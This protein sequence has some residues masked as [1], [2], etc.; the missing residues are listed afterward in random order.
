MPRFDSAFCDPASRRWILIAAILGSSMG[1]IDGSVVA[2]AI[3]AIRA[4]LG[5]SLAEAQWINNAYMVAISALVL[6]GGSVGDRFG[7]ARIFTLGILVFL[8]A[9]IACAAAPS[10]DALIWARWVQGGG[11]A[12]MVPGSLA[13]IARAYP[14][15]VRGRAI[16]YWAGASAM[17]TA[18]GPVIGGLVM[19]FG[20]DGMWRSVFAVNLPL[21]LVALWLVRRHVRRDRTRPDRGL[22]IPGAVLATL[23]L[24]L[25]AWGCIRIETG[26]GARWLLAGGAAALVLFLLAEW[27]APRPIMPLDLFRD[28]AFRV[29]NLAT[30][31]LYF[32]LS[33]I[34]FFLPMLL[35]SGWGLNE[36]E[37]VLALGPIAVTIALLSRPFGKLGDRLGPVTMICAGSLVVALGYWWLSHAVTTQT[38]WGGIIVPMCVI[39]LGM[40]MVVAP[41]STAIMAGAGEDAGGVASGVNNAVSRVAGLFAVAAMGPVVASAYRRA[42]GTLSYGEVRESS[43]IHVAA[44][45]EAFSA[46]AT[47]CAV[48]AAIAAA[49]ALLAIIRPPRRR[50]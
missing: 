40:A 25:L 18:L 47:I 48:F 41:L 27:R 36:I 49:I 45:T 38:F 26:P 19:S 31:A 13:I 33:A 23:G 14:R 16:G 4:G 46:V 20:P 32:G 2:I 6:A 39:A 10:A 29:S 42:G 35:I 17:T 7:T 24:G 8:A 21:G 1:F 44:M 12:L 22:D 34:V 5:A 37:A 11:A 43:E 3:P 50:A 28:R 15:E 30:F 9:S